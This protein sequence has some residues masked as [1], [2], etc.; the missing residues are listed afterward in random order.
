[1]CDKKII[2]YSFTETGSRLQLFLMEHLREIQPDCRAYTLERYAGAAGLHPLPKGWKEE[3]GKYWGNAG[4]IFIGA[5]GIAVRAIAHYV[6]DKFS[7]SPVIVMDEAGRF[8][9]PLLSGHVGGAVELAE[10]IASY[11]GGIPVITTATDV[12]KRFAVDVFAK[13]NN[14]TL[15]DRFLAKKI[16]ADILEGKEVGLYSEFFFAGCQACDKTVQ[17]TV[18]SE[19]PEGIRICSSLQEL[20]GF[21]HGICIAQCVPEQ[22][23]KH[24]LLLLPRN[25]YLGIGCRKG[26]S[27]L[28][29]EKELQKLFLEKRIVKEQI[30]AMGSIDLKKTEQG[31]L[32]YAKAL[33]IPF[34]TFSAEE[35]EQT[36][37]VENVSEFVKS[38]TGVDNVCERSAMRLCMEGTV[39]QEKYCMDQVTASLV[40]GEI[41]IKF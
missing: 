13:K 21:E 41:R 32:E 38:V 39:F 10:Q 14:L 5:A 24:V 2:L 3:I 9:I 18:L 7:D 25:L 33:E 34:S 16:S 23:Q 8:V 20:S 15:S 29:I 1:M 22:L 19:I 31:L 17:R 40:K 6:K 12:Q 36:G 35:L 26:V 37:S 28:H 11:T 30:C 27:F 4:F